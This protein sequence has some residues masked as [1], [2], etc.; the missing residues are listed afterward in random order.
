MKQIVLIR[1]LV[2]RQESG[3]YLGFIATV[4]H[5]YLLMM[6]VANCPLYKVAHYSAG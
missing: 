3:T 6:G 4:R 2:L 1:D 5:W